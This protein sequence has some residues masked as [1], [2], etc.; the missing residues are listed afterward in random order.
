MHVLL[1]KQ[2]VNS[3]YNLDK[4]AKMDVDKL[5]EHQLFQI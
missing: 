3:L 1:K 2:S 4:R 5:D